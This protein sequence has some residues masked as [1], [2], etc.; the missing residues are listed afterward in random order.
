MDPGGPVEKNLLKLGGAV[1]TP[2]GTIYYF[3]I[4][5]IIYWEY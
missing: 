1:K 2:C 4:V 3:W 5:N